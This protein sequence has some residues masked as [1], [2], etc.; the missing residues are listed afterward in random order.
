MTPAD[1]TICDREPITRLQRIQTFGFLVAMSSDWV[2][3][4]VSSNLQSILGV[5]PAATL[6]QPLG[7]GRGHRRGRAAVW[8]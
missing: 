2:I 5:E 3:T 6:G 4:F 1:L 8:G 7:G